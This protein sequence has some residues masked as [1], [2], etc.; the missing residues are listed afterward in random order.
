MKK[1]FLLVQ[2]DSHLLEK[3]SEV[4]FTYPNG[5]K[6]I[7]ISEDVRDPSAIVVE[8]ELKI[9][10]VSLDHIQQARNLSIRGS[11]ASE[12][13]FGYVELI[14]TPITDWLKELKLANIDI[15]C[16][17]PNNTYLCHA[18]EADFNSIKK[19]KSFILSIV[20]L[21]PNLK[22]R[23][24]I[25]EI[26]RVWILFGGSELEIKQAIERLNSITGIEIDSQIDL[27]RA[28]FYVQVKA[29]IRKDCQDKIL[30]DDQVLG[31]ELC[32]KRVL[33]DERVGLI[34]A[35]QYTEE[36]RIHG[37]Y[38]DWLCKHSV[39]GKG[40]TIAIVDSGSVDPQHP[41]F[42]GR[43][44]NLTDHVTSDPHTAEVACCAAGKDLSKFEKALTRSVSDKNFYTLGIAPEADLLIVPFTDRD[45][46][47][48]IQSCCHKSVNNTGPNG[49]PVLIQNNSWGFGRYDTAKQYQ[50]HEAIYDQMVR[51]ANLNPDDPKPLT[52]CFSAG[53]YGTAGLTRPKV[54]K[55]IIVTGSSENYRLKEGGYKADNI[56]EVAEDSSHGN[57]ADRRIRPDIVAPSE[58]TA[59][60]PKELTSDQPGF[61]RGTSLSSPRTAGACALIIQWWQKKFGQ[62]PS[63]AIIR[64]LIVNG[65]VDINYQS[66]I[67]N[68]IQGW[69][70][71]NLENIFDESCRRFYL[72]QTVLLNTE[73]L[74]SWSSSFQVYDETRPLKITLSWTDPPGSTNSGTAEAP[75]IVNEL[76]LRVEVGKDLYLGN[77]FANGWSVPG[78]LKTQEDRSNNSYS[79]LREGI[80]NLQNV[81][82]PAGICKGEFKVTVAALALRQNCFNFHSEELVQDFALVITN[83]HR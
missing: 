34:V 60:V 4:L 1:N 33:E 18:T 75:A 8:R 74:R 50:S 59:T 26:E 72:D 61:N 54:A 42:D 46:E 40:V 20:P 10:N 57:C 55:N 37:S 25:P 11:S 78:L 52:I 9:P 51:D 17:Q 56:N 80:D 82:L 12:K 16:Y 73:S 14:S 64:A 49:F 32:Q 81:Y 76:A 31:I 62:K 5:S 36:G 67:P 28:S 39:D 77:N 2:P 68:M 30:S 3:A 58:C 38:F 63:P 29:R 83:S 43:L 65:A 41:A 15:L 45:N 35:G 13:V 24:D 22:S 21:T 27:N 23:V 44:K 19:D 48:A 69:G 7:E 6:L 53:N 79:P 66:N 47:E 70:R 71:L